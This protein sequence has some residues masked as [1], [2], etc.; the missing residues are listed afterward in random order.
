MKKFLSILMVLAMVLSLSVTAFADQETGSI[1]ITNAT[2]GKTYKIYKI[3]DA[4]I[5][6]D[7]TGEADAISYSIQPGSQ[8]FDVLFGTTNNFFDYNTNTHAV[9]KKDRVNDTALITYLTDLINDENANY[10]MAKDPIVAQADADVVFTDLPYGYYVI[11]S[12]LGSAVTITSNA[13]DASV[14]DKN[15]KPGSGFDKLM[16]D[17]DENGNISWVNHNSANIGDA[18]TY[19]ITFEAT[20]YDG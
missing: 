2:A 16:K 19:K 17:T 4:S 15:Q 12:G 5:N 20:N 7:A 10:T 14:I 18:V 11:T 13:P 9:T 6:K 8:F 1:T 3:F